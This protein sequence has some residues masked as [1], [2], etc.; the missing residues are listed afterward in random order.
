MNTE[1]AAY[2]PDCRDCR[3]GKPHWHAR[4][5]YEQR[6]GHN[7]LELELMTACEPAE[8][9]LEIITWREYRQ[10]FGRRPRPIRDL[11]AC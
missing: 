9:V 10:G 3:K 6:W 5:W 1:L 4:Q 8:L 7:G 11:V 2:D